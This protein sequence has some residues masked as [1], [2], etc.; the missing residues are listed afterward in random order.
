MGLGK[1]IITLSTI[2]YR[3]RSGQIQAALVFGPKRVMEAVWEKEARKWEHT[4]HLTFSRIMGDQKRRKRALFAKAHIYLCNYENMSW[5]SEMLHQFYIDQGRPLPFQMVVYDEITKLKNAASQRMKGGRR[6]VDA[7]E[8]TER[9]IKVFGWKPVIRHIPYRTGL[10]GTPASNGYID[11]H[12]QFLA[13]D[14]GQRLGEYVTH[15]RQQ[16]FESDYMG[17]NYQVTDAGKAEIE[18]RIADITLRM[19]TEDYLELPPV[20]FNNITVTLPPKARK[21]YDE[22]ERQMFTELDTGHAVEVFSRASATNKC[23]QICNGFAF[24]DPETDERAD[25][26]AAKLDA[27]ES[28]IEEA[29]GNPVFVAYTFRPDSDRIQDRFKKLK[30]VDLGRISERELPRVLKRWAEGRIPLMLGH[31]ASIGH[32]ID[33]LQDGGNTLVFF[34]LPWSL[35]LYDQTV[36]RFARQGQSRSVTVHRILAEDTLD[37]A[38]L[39]ALETKDT[40][41]RGLMDAIKRFRVESSGLSFL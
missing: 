15:F 41:Q 26:H 29:A 27:L 8:P 3:L 28:I 4:R 32:G 10:T 16:Y 7:G 34:G 23:L 12:G 33:G 11:L 35:D 18:R 6:T 31:P 39:D 30:P 14:G 5:L 25:L 20:L 36:A 38:V 2:E 22:M 17:W 9:T 40:T 21:A 1:T 13:V 19:A 24:L 37:F